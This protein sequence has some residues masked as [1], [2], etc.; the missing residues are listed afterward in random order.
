MNQAGIEGRTWEARV[1]VKDEFAEEAAVAALDVEME[2]INPCRGTN[3]STSPGSWS[4]AGSPTMSGSSFVGLV[5]GGAGAIFW[6]SCE[7]RTRRGSEGLACLF[8]S[9]NMQMGWLFSSA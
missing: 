7:D 4:P 8:D 6:A 3:Q 9:V 1:F 2:Q 5:E